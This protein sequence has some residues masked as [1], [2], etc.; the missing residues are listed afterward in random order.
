MKNHI[1]QGAECCACCAC[2]DSCPVSAIE[3]QLNSNGDLAPFVNEERC[4]SCGKCLSVCPYMRQVRIL[5]DKQFYI[6]TNLEKSLYDY[7]AS[8]GIF[9]ALAKYVLTIGG[10]V[11]GAA[12]VQ[13]GA[14]TISCAHIGISSVS[15]LS[16]L[17]GSKY[18]HSQ[19]AGV[20]PQVK[21]ILL[22]GKTVLFS[23]TSCQV[24][25]L[26]GYLKKHYENLITVDLVCHGVPETT[27]LK[28]YLQF[29]EK[30]LNCKILDISFRRK[31]APGY[32]SSSDSYILTLKCMNEAT[33]EVYEKYIPKT[34]SAYFLLFL[35]RAGYRA[36]CYTC[37]YASI[38]K[39][40]D[41]T[42]GDFRP[43]R[44]EVLRYQLKHNVMWSSILVHTAKG[45]DILSLLTNVCELHEIGIDTMLSHHMNLKR[46]SVISKKGKK[47]LAVY[48]AKGFTGLQ[49]KI[50]CEHKL[51]YIPR[52]IIKLLRKG[53]K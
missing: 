52:A 21:K 18:V 29:L 20:Y 50:D 17:Q 2:V 30:K 11:F 44:E 48:H 25:G 35:Q 27:V 6:A 14:D 12:I 33:G 39:P 23:G 28:K 22:E 1:N 24:D 10:T 32:E 5:D 36:N 38:H 7:S 42:L 41:I 15:E 34:L 8:G 26:Y 49:K 45:R 53:L 37:R 31:K 47:L 16:R 40:A 43:T 19:T 46:P 51:F 9:S 13:D 3:F 4:V